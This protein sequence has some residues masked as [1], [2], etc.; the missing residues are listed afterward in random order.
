MHDQVKTNAVSPDNS[1]WSHIRGT[2][3]IGIPLIGAQL[4]Q[5]GI[6]TTDVVIL[7]QFGAQ[8]LAAIVLAG[9]FLFTVFVFGTG[10]SMAVVP[11]VAQAY[12]RGDVT[13]VR[14]SLRM[15]LWV[16]IGYWLLMQPVFFSAETILIHLGQQPETAALAGR[17]VAMAEF[18]LLPGLLFIALR[19]MVSA[20]NRAGVVLWATVFML[21]TNA[22]LAYVLVLGHFGLPAMGMD[23]AAIVA[24]L[25]QFA[26][27]AVLITYIQRVP[28]TRSYQVFVR[29]WRPDW[30][31]LKEVLRLGFP[32]C[33]TILAEV[34]LFSACSLMM[35][36]IG[37]VELA[38][39]GIAL[40]LA[41]ITFMIPLGLGQ[42]ATVRVGVAHGRGDFVGV[43]RAAITVVILAAIISLSGG[44]AFATIPE[45][46]AVWFL[47]PETPN[48]AAVLTYAGP[49]IVTAGLFQLFDGQQAIF[50]SLLRG[51]KDARVPM[52]LALIAYWPVGFTMAWAL[53]F[54]LGFGGLG[55]WLG[56]VFGLIGAS[57]MLCLRFIMLLRRERLVLLARA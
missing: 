17:Y 53:A 18:G 7:G 44:I 35:G 25:V 24:V 43:R 42:G 55:V 3:A 40:Q 28:E 51:L 20:I 33:I 14:R 26:G 50:A 10:F 21:V 4:A 38:A 8:Y 49:L 54:P 41:S 9:Q 29:F 11:M 13:S 47:N 46:L 23:G 6:H 52:V 36:A 1:W 16:A 48:A 2:F 39:H 34:S 5:L 56:I 15:G 45:K 30:L 57:T 27:L 31:A 19:S 22:A 32:I 12:G 37:T